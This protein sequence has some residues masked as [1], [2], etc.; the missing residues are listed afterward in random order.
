MDFDSAA[1]DAGVPDTV[2]AVPTGNNQFNEI[3][4]KAEKDILEPLKNKIKSQF[5]G[6][7]IPEDELEELLENAAKDALA[8]PNKWATT[9]NNY[10]YTINSNKLIDL[11]KDAVKT[12]IKAKGYEF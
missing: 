8:N 3:Q 12:G 9:T 4:A 1:D 6:S 5:S 10:T 7:D 11:F 2:T